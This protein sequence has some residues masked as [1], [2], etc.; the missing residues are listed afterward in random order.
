[1]V[2]RG[3]TL[4]GCELTGATCVR[5]DQTSAN[6]K[7]IT[8]NVQAGQPYYFLVDGTS[9]GAFD[10]FTITFLASSLGGAAGLGAYSS[11]TCPHFGRAAACFFYG[12]DGGRASGSV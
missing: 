4:R 7:T 11:I 12:F 8:I 3:G 10:D 1:M 5:H 9:C 6:P 2:Y